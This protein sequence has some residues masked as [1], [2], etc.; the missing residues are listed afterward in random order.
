MKTVLRRLGIVAGLALAVGTAAELWGRTAFSRVV[1]SD[2]ETLLAGSS[3]GDAKFVTEAML[4]GLPEP[5]Q[6]YLRYTGVIGKPLVRT[7]HL[8]QRGKMLLASGQPWIPL[9]AQHG[10]PLDTGV[11]LVRHAADRPDTDR[12]CARHVPDRGRADADQGGLTHH[13]GRREGQG[14]PGSRF[15]SCRAALV[16]QT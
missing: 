15:S 11:C 16:T 5:V 9:Q 7:V 12:A 3:A 8:R 4:D 10:T 1:Q 6:R 13:G 2:V 14:D